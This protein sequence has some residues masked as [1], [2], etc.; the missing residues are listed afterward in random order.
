MADELP[1]KEAPSSSTSESNGSVTVMTSQAP[2]KSGE[3]TPQSIPS[4]LPVLPLSDLV[5]FPFMVAPLLVSSQ[6]SIKLVDDVVAGN[7]L[8][9]L[10]LQKNPDIENPQ[11]E[12][13]H[14]YGCVGKVL[15][16]LRFPDESV[17]IL[18][19]GLRRVRL[20]K[21]EKREPYLVAQV[22]VLEEQTEKSVE[23]NALAR[24]AANQF[25][26]VVG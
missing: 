15:K 17:R 12:D 3:F 16:M 1:K 22:A 2:P 7:R 6:S 19:Q 20:V 21:I 9:V 26:E 8:L 11:E 18:V 10:V 14:E 23:L 24:N 13:L 4:E 25:Q 5:V